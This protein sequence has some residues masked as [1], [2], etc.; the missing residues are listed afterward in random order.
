MCQT[1]GS[2]GRIHPSNTLTTSAARSCRG[3]SVKRRRVG[4]SHCHTPDL[5]YTSSNTTTGTEHTPCSAAFRDRRQRRPRP[6]AVRVRVLRLVRP[7]ALVRRQREG[8][9]ALPGGVRGGAAARPFRQ[10]M[11]PP[12][13]TRTRIRSVTKSA[14]GKGRQRLEMPRQRRSRRTA[15]AVRQRIRT[16]RVRRAA[17]SPSSLSRHAAS[18]RLRKHPQQLQ[19]GAR[20][21]MEAMAWLRGPPRVEGS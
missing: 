21:L 11:R 2:T 1:P 8:G 13:K 6:R 15:W 19:T 5:P 9:V 20:G 4:K 18:A 14:G 7:G 10:A 12:A 17:G 3:G 16:S